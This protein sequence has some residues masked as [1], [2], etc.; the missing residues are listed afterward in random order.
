MKRLIIPMIVLMAFSSC[1]KDKDEVTC[2]ASVSG[3]AGNYKVTKVVISVS[4]FPDT[5]VTSSTL[6]SCN[7]GGIYQLKADKTAAYTES[8]ACANNDSGKWDVASNNLSI[9]FEPISGVTLDGSAISGWDC[10]TLVLSK[11]AG[12]GTFKYTLTKQ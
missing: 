7:S 9:D 6:S 4:G 1:K 2:E 10:S 3:I 11:N 5:D 8:T 12:S